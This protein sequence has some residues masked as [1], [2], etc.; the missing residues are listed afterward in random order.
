MCTRKEET[1]SSGF[2]KIWFVVS[3]DLVS[4]GALGE[5]GAKEKVFEEVHKRLTDF[6]AV[7]TW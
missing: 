1:E 7:L 3:P 6:S 4:P 2:P 5:A